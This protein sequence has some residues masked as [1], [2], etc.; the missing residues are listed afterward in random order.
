MKSSRGFIL[1][2]V[3]CYLLVL[4]ILVLTAMEQSLLAYRL[5]NSLQHQ[6]KRALNTDMVLQQIEQRLLKNESFTCIAP[7]ELA[8]QFFM[9]NKPASQAVRFCDEQVNQVHYEYI[10]EELPRLFCHKQVDGKVLVGEL[11]RINLF[12]V[13]KT[14]ELRLQSVLLRPINSEAFDEC[15]W[16]EIMP[17][18]GRLSWRARDI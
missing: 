1:I 3:L 6:Q 8:N 2:T 18:F 7:G 17:I 16:V 13:E 4:S 12:A 11:L 15:H 5:A 10:I 9:Q 14:Y